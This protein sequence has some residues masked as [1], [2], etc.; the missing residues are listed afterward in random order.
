MLNPAL[1]ARLKSVFGTVKVSNHGIEAGIDYSSDPPVIISSGE[2]Y[3]VCCPFCGDRRF[4][5]YFSYLYGQV[6]D[7]GKTRIRFGHLA[8]CHNEDCLSVKENR[9]KL[10][11][12]LNQESWIP[13][14]VAN[15]EPQ[16]PRSVSPPKNLLPLSALGETHPAIEYLRS[17]DFNI[18]YLESKGF[19]Y[20]PFDP[21]MAIMSGR[22]FIPIY[23]LY[24][25]LIGGQGRLIYASDPV[26]PKY[27]TLP[28]SRLQRS[29]YNIQS[30]VGKDFVVVTEGVFDA[31]R[32]GDHGI[33]MLGKTLGPYRWQLLTSLWK[34]IVLMPD[35]DVDEDDLLP[36]NQ[37]TALQRI[38]VEVHFVRL[39][40]DPADI[41]SLEIWQ[42]LRQVLQD[43][44]LQME[45]GTCARGNG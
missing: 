23:D 14:T 35:P 41:S 2:E 33:A 24:G 36:E 17:R 10:S 44:S 22:I 11:E 8:H 13:I 43:D 27:W 40:S 21:D 28:G 9:T 18:Y 7:T 1:F 5:L 45:E 37:K 6:V 34:K 32:I 25:N 38:G 15:T 4:R 39:S 20:C 29:F 3:R 30:A 31:L 26:L 19:A 16:Q 42:I 12:L